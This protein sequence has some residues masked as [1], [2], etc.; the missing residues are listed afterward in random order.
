MSILDKD[1][2]V[3]LNILI[4]TIESKHPIRVNDFTKSLEALNHLYAQV[5]KS[6]K[7]VKEE[8]SDQPRELSIFSVNKCCIRLFLME[9]NPIAGISCIASVINTIIAGLSL[10]WDVHNSKR[11]TILNEKLIELEKERNDSE[12]ARIELEKAR[13][14][15]EKERIELEK[16]GIKLSRKQLEELKDIKKLLELIR[17]P[18]DSMTLNNS[19]G[20]EVVK[21]DYKTK[22]QLEKTIENLLKLGFRKYS[23]KKG[24]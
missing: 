9:S 14:E 11:N 23:K 16:Q 1:F 19:D 12:K 21:M 4:V 15:L 18:G 20:K 22:K 2:D 10:A 13:I 24:K 5:V 6:Q 17:E 7:K 3:K 8:S